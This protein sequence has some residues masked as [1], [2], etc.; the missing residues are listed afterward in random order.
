MSANKGNPT[1]AESSDT[2]QSIGARKNPETETAILDAA[3]EI[4]AEKGIGGLRM[5]AVARRA[6]AGKATL[7]RWWPSRGTLLLAVYQRKKPNIIYRDTGSLYQDFWHFAHDLVTIWKGD[8][9]L[10]FKALIAEAESDPDVAEKLKEYHAERL[11]ALCA[12]TRRARNRGDIPANEDP[13]IRAE[14]LSSLLWQRLINNRLDEKIDEHVR[15]LA[16]S[17]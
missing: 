11:A 6:K 15:V 1:P 4:I 7:Y 17:D 10:F 9:G 14:I 5:E 8:N 16:N 12:I 13:M 2:R 3:A